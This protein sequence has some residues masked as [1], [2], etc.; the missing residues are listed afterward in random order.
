MCR[1]GHLPPDGLAK[2]RL[3]RNKKRSKSADE[4]VAAK[5]CAVAGWPSEG[6]ALRAGALNK[7]PV[8]TR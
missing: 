5:R 2:A 7:T 6:E 4:A 3:C 8:G 1:R